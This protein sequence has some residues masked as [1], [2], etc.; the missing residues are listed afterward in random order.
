MKTVRTS[1]TT[2]RFLDR[3]RS[4]RKKARLFPPDHAYV[5][6]AVKDLYTIVRDQLS[7]KAPVNY[8]IAGGELYFDGELQAGESVAYSDLLEDL[9]QRELV[10]WTITEGLTFTELVRF[11]ALT[12][13]KV[14]QIRLR[15][16][17]ETVCIEEGV[18]HI[19]PNRSFVATGGGGDPRR[20]SD[21]EADQRRRISQEAYTAAM[22]AAIS[23][24]MDAHARQML[25]LDMV[26][27]VVG[28]LVSTLSN[29]TQLF[30][31]VHA[32]KDADEYTFSHS[33]NVAILALLMGSKLNLPGALLHR[34]GV[35]AMLHDIGKTHVPDDILN[36]PDQLTPDEWKIMQS[37][38]LEG[39]KILSEQAKVDHL[40]IVIA[41][42][43]HA[44]FDM[45]GYPKFHALSRLHTLSRLMAVVDSYD[46]ITSDRSYRKALLPDQAMKI[47]LQGRGSQFDP[48]MVKIFA[49]MTGMFP[50]GTFV[51]L[52][53][54]ECGVV[55]QANPNEL[56]RPLV[57][58]VQKGAR[59]LAEYRIVDLSE[60]ENGDYKRNIVRSIDPTE[61][62]LDVAGLL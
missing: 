60:Q 15:N 35:A 47:L 22:E 62:G 2:G 14:E 23:A 6:A 41:A 53:T 32:I 24:F 3:L 26:E 42:Q 58:V 16:G 30:G 1:N 27:G 55:I 45:L 33:V 20:R 44:R 59:Q 4:A 56:Y 57:K 37:H 48:V 52:D 61:L 43:H 46:A 38:T 19:I 51:L 31:S 28:L 8:A 39:V 50:V 25:N 9:T 21:P 40:T 17:W 49:Q 18:H 54:H 11:V 5:R 12:N 36:K 34:L 7:E 29:N 13:E 10:S